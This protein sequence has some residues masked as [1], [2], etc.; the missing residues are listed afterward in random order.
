MSCTEVKQLAKDHM[1]GTPA[2]WLQHHRAT[3]LHFISGDRKKIGILMP[4]LNPPTK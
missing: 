4:S 3:M 2:I 1:A